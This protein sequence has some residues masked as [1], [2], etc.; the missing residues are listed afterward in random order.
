QDIYVSTADFN[1]LNGQP[2]LK[3]HGKSEGTF[4]ID[5]IYMTDTVPEGYVAGEEIETPPAT[6]TTEDETT[7]TTSSQ[8]DEDTTTTTQTSD[9][10]PKT[11]SPLPV[12]M[13]ILALTA[14]VALVTVSGKKARS[15]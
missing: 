11:G 9:E 2:Y 8:D 10:S 6:T 3:L 5:C 14:A 1:G 12:V 13:I 7:D 15:F 4:E